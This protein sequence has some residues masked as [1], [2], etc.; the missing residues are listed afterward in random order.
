MKT[1]IYFLF[2]IF[3]FSLYAENSQIILDP[4]RG[5][6][7]KKS[8][9][10]D[11]IDEP[12]KA[13]SSGEQS[14]EY[15]LRSQVYEEEC[16]LKA[17]EGGFSKECLLTDIK[18]GIEQCVVT[19]NR[20]MM[21][22]CSFDDVTQDNL[23]ETELHKYPL[24][25]FL[26]Q[27]RYLRD[28]F[29]TLH[30]EGEYSEH[31]HLPQDPETIKEEQD[32]EELEKYIVSE[33]HLEEIVVPELVDK[34]IGGV[35]QVIM[36][37]FGRSRSIGSGF[38]MKDAEDQ[39]VFITNYH[40]VGSMLRSL[41]RMNSN[42]QDWSFENS[43]LLFYVVQQG[44]QKFRIKGVR[45]MSLLMD[46]AVLE[47]EHYTGDVLNLADHYSNET[48]IY[49]LGYLG[50]KDLKKIKAMHPFK[51]SELFTSFM[52][53]VNNCYTLQG[54]SGS[55]ALNPK[56]EVVGTASSGMM[57]FPDC[58]NLNIIPFE[59]FTHID[60]MSSVKTSQEDI[61]GLIKEQE[62]LFYDQLLSDS[63]LRVD[64]VSR[65]ALY[66]GSG[67]FLSDFLHSVKTDD[68]LSIYRK[69]S[70]S[71]QELSEEDRH[72]LQFLVQKKIANI[73][74]LDTEYAA[75]LGSKEAKMALGAELYYQGEFEKAHQLFQE[76]VQFREPIYLYLLS[77][78]YY[79]N[80]KNFSQ[81]CRL[82]TYS[83]EPVST[84]DDLYKRYECESV[85]TEI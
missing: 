43:Q 50:N 69:L 59:G 75:Q 66:R 79:Y 39:P 57:L 2:L 41:F 84:L 20:D 73:Q 18:Y 47:V 29:I 24:E 68:L 65:A 55:P 37:L 28:C 72:E 21:R 6:S 16:S 5:G 30:E 76:L 53:S 12:S 32:S 58:T 33:T 34:A 70:E 78:L 48:P 22:E 4:F 46:L 25:V 14:V 38:F 61:A 13:V 17:V 27:P 1:L 54:V 64:L 45:D 80:E 62:L 40:V 56:G 36:D 8:E 3:S 71:K 10:S 15:G 7:N 85:L 82:L 26:E 44:D 11:S 74:G 9:D 19:G 42:N 51:M 63:K 35:G 60:L 83:K 23:D 52:L 77:G 67:M 49:V 81:A 31:C